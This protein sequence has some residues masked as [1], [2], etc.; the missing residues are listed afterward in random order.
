MNCLSH[1]YSLS[2]NGA[3]LI[4][5][6]QENEPHGAKVATAGFVWLLAATL[7][8]WHGREVI[9]W[10]RGDCAPLLAVE[11][12]HQVIMGENKGPYILQNLGHLKKA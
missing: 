7:N 9:Q 3:A 5:V 2:I 10:Q 8:G 4:T 1:L 12:Y 11:K 6:P